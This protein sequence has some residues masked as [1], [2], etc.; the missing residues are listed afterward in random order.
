[1]DSTRKISDILQKELDMMEQQIATW[2]KD[3]PLHNLQD[4]EEV[5]RQGDMS[6]TIIANK[7]KKRGSEG[8]REKKGNKLIKSNGL[9]TT[10]NRFDVLDTNSDRLMIRVNHTEVGKE[11]HT[12]KEQF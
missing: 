12:V 10:A 4:S 3:I 1:L 7:S 2:N 11:G 5:K 6:W 8:N 9:V